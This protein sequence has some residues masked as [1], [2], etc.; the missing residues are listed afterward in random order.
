MQALFV[1]FFHGIQNTLCEPSFD[2]YEASQCYQTP[3]DT[4][5]IWAYLHQLMVIPYF[6]NT[7]KLLNFLRKL[8]LQSSNFTFVKDKL[9]IS[10]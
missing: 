1:Y 4:K 10:L 2:V 6:F 3:H 9:T 8:F 5:S 7:V